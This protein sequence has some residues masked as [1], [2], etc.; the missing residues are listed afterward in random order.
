[1]LGSYASIVVK[2]T[3]IN[4]LLGSKKMKLKNEIKKKKPLPVPV[5]A[6]SKLRAM[7][8]EL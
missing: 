5:V 3:A 7:S 4:Q 1:L 6:M 8:C 2:K